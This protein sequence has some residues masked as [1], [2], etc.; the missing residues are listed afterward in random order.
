MKAS[1]E[2]LFVPKLR[3]VSKLL[4]RMQVGICKVQWNYDQH[5]NKKTRYIAN[6]I[7]NLFVFVGS[8]HAHKAHIRQL[9]DTPDCPARMRQFLHYAAAQEDNAN[10]EPVFIF[11]AGGRVARGTECA[12]FSTQYKYLADSFGCHKMSCLNKESAKRF[13]KYFSDARLLLKQ[14]R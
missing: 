10:E 6:L 12:R 7:S 2:L 3:L 13:L 14:Q 11:S 1:Y 8:S 5:K 4:V 9:K